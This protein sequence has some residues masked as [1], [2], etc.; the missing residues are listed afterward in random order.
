[1]IEENNVPAGAKGVICKDGCMRLFLGDLCESVSADKILQVDAYSPEEI[2]NMEISV[3]VGTPATYYKSVKTLKKSANFT[4]LQFACT[5]F[6]DDYFRPL[7]EWKNVNTVTI[8]SKNVT[9]NKL[10]FI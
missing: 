7:T 4:G 2:Y 6:K 1:M 3:S 10:T 9:I 8:V 5:D